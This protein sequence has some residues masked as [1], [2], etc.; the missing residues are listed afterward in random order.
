M[1]KTLRTS[2]LL[3][4]RMTGGPGAGSA[5]ARLLRRPEQPGGFGRGELDRVAFDLVQAHRAEQAGVLDGEVARG[6]TVIKVEVLVPGPP[7]R[8]EQGP[9]GPLDN[10]LGLAFVVDD[11][12]AVPLHA[13][14]VGLGGVPVPDRATARLEL[15]HV[16]I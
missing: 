14:Q 5:P 3:S 9:L 15:G 8:C 4:T 2:S 11:R 7:G 6:V 13:V 16:G 1:P 10:L 12:A